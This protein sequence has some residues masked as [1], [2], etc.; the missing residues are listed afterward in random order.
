MSDYLSHIAERA[1][2]APA[3]VRPA[4]PSLFEPVK[5]EG[6]FAVASMARGTEPIF[7]IEHHLQP[8]CEASDKSRSIHDRVASI[9]TILTTASTSPSPPMSEPATKRTSADNVRSPIAEPTVGVFAAESNVVVEPTAESPR[10]QPAVWPRTDQAAELAQKQSIVG[11]AMPTSHLLVNAEP[12]PATHRAAPSPAT[13]AP[14]VPFLIPAITPVP[15][16]PIASR[17]RASAK[18]AFATE[19]ESSPAP[20]IHVT[21]GRVEVRAILPATNAT[22]PPAL[23]VPK[24]SLDD[25]LKTRNGGGV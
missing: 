20:I 25:Y 22:P 11:D 2:S 23:S 14:A 16:A 13:V 4:L 19:A 21:I 5:T 1:G 6:G 3:A 7:E 17:E 10:K 24:L 15:S 18:T 8:V 12:T 9:Q